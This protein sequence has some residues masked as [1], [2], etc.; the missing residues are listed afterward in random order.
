MPQSILESVQL[1]REMEPE[2]IDCSNIWAFKEEQGVEDTTEI[3]T[4]TEKPDEIKEKKENIV[5]NQDWKM[6]ALLKLWT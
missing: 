5:S 3:D 4:S 2:L 1:R 6:W